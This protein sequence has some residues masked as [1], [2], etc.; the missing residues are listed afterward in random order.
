MFQFVYWL[1]ALAA[2]L[3]TNS[4]YADIWPASAMAFGGHYGNCIYFFLS[5][6]CL[7]N[8]GK[9]FPKWYAKRIVRVYPALWIVAVV[10]LAVK[11]WSADGIMAYIHCLIYPT[12][13]HFISSIMILYLIYYIIRVIQKKDGYFPVMVSDSSAC[14]IS[15]DVCVFV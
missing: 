7:Y 10:N 6:F 12:W 4:H 9:S 13:Y 1:R 3:I 8:I 11:F 2:I 14:G 15:V 5:G